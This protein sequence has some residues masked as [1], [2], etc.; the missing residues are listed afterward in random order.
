MLE[1]KSD[2]DADKNVQADELLAFLLTW[3]A[4]HIKRSDMRYVGCFHEHGM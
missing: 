1:L 3:F 4:E 2:I